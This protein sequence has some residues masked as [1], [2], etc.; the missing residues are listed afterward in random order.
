MLP[1]FPKVYNIGHPYLADLFDG[2]VLVQ[3]K[4]DGSQFSFGVVDG[5]IHFRSKN[6]DLWPG[7]GGM[8]DVGMDA[9]M[10]VMPM[11]TPGWVYRGEYLAKPKHNCLKYD[12]VPKH[13][14]IIFDVTTGP[15]SYLS[16]YELREEAAR[17]DL[18]L[19]P[20]IFVGEVCNEGQVKLMLENGSVLGG[21]Q[22]EGVVVKNYA[23]FGYDGRALMGKY[24][25]E[26]FKERNKSNWRKENPTQSDIIVRIAAEY[27]TEARW[28]KAVQHLAEAGTLEHSPRD[29]GPLIGEVQKDIHSEAGDEIK[30]MLFKWAW[31]QVRR[32]VTR[33]FPEWYKGELLK[34]Q[35]DGGD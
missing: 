23:R 21:T 6:N 19:V 2:P 17:L 31:E 7:K 3:E 15:E 1:S 30:E 32:Q 13:H 35:F 11:L 18:D 22:V 27:T 5:E 8:F 28:R 34:R 20:F 16:P 14:V 33:G 4:V 25:R 12:R 24:V 29:I 10:G 26:D 9:L